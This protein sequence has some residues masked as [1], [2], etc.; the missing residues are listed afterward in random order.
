[1]ATSRRKHWDLSLLFFFSKKKRGAGSEKQKKKKTTSL[2]NL[3]L[4]WEITKL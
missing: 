2:K 4:F 1:M 3:D